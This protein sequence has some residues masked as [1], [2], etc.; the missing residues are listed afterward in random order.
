MLLPGCGNGNSGKPIPSDTADKLINNIQKADEYNSQGLCSRAH[1]K[2]KDARFVLTQVPDNVDP[3]LTQGIADGLQHMDSLITS[4][5]QK[6]ASTQTQ[7]QTTQTQTTPTVTETQTTPTETTQTQT[8]PT[9][10][11]PTVTTPT[12]TTQTGT[13]TGT[14]TGNGGTPTGTGATGATGGADGAT[15]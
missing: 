10:T 9:A 15:G 2:V 5:C 4:E 14:T 6:P 11:Q 7:T 1:T 3:D 12:Q 8:T 13:G